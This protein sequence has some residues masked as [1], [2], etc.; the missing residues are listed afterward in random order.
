MHRHVLRDVDQHRGEAVGAGEGEPDLVPPLRR[1]TVG[2]V[3]FEQ[4]ETSIGTWDERGDLVVELGDVETAAGTTIELGFTPA[5]RRNDVAGR[6][7]A[8]LD[9]AEIPFLTK[10][11]VYRG[12]RE[13]TTP[14]GQMR[15]ITALDLDADLFEALS[16]I[17]L[18][19]E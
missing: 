10:E 17:V 1:Y 3:G 8:F 12:V 4:A 7:F 14:A 19:Q 18:A 15:A 9:Q 16:E 11:F 5:V 2:S 6:V 13:A